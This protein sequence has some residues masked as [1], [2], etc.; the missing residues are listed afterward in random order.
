MI[1]KTTIKIFIITTILF[2]LTACGVGTSTDGEKENLQDNSNWNSMKWDE[3]K[4][5]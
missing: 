2:I 4:W 1:F 3:G 5:L